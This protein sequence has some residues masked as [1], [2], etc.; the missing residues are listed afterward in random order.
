MVALMFLY[1]T[2]MSLEAIR[3]DL[4]LTLPSGADELF[5]SAIILYPIQQS[6]L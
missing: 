3:F 1:D 2:Y 5:K 6:E 4:V